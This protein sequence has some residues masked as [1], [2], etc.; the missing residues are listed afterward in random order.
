[1][2]ACIIFILTH[3]PFCISIGIEHK[4]VHKSEIYRLC[5]FIDGLHYLCTV[6]S[7]DWQQ[8]CRWVLI[9]EICRLGRS[10]CRWVRFIERL[11]YIYRERMDN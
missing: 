6:Q 4:Y 10:I 7:A 2:L 5:K 8:I 9:L 1:M 3:F 11:E